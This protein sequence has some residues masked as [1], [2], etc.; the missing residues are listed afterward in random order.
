MSPALTRRAPKQDVDQL[1]K[2]KIQSSALIPLDPVIESDN[3][4]WDNADGKL[5]WMLEHEKPFTWTFEF[6]VKPDVPVGSTQEVSF[7]IEAQ[8]C[9]ESKCT[10]ENH[11][12]KVSIP[13]GPEEPLTPAADIAGRTEPVAP[14]VVPVTGSIEPSSTPGGET[15]DDT[16]GGNQPPSGLLQA[17][18][19]AVGGG[20]ISLLTP[21]V[22]PMI[23]ITVSYFLKQSEPKL[24]PVVHTPSSDQFQSFPRPP[25]LDPKPT[26]P[27]LLALV[28]SLT[29]VLVLT[30]GG[31]S[32]GSALIQIS[33]H[34][35]TNFALGAVFLF[36]G[37]SLFGWYDVTLPSWLQ[38]VT[39]SGEGRGGLLGVFFMALTFSIVSFSCVGP[40]YGIFIAG[41]AAGSSGQL[42]LV[43]SVVAFAVAFASP[44]FFLALFPQLLETMPRAGSWMNSVK[45]VMGFLEIAAVV[46]FVRAGELASTGAAEYLSY[47]LS[48]GIYVAL[49]VACGLYL[50]GVYRLPHDHD[51]PETIAVPRLL[52]GLGF[53]TLALY[54]TPGLF[55]SAGGQSM[56]PRGIVF[57]W[58]DSFRLPDP[59]EAPAGKPGAPSGETLVWNHQL[60]VALEQAKKE[61]KLV[62]IDFTGTLCTN[63]KLN[64]RYA[65]PRPEIQAAMSKYVLL[66]LYTDKTPAGVEQVPS[67]VSSLELRNKRFE[68]NA[69]PHY[70]I[71]R[72]EGDDF[73]IVRKYGGN[74]IQSP[75]ERKAFVEFLTK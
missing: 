71:L 47:D 5:D 43:I 48:L 49:C 70:A 52:F 37:L 66:K 26:S 63:C 67:E 1:A 27:L 21:C 33:T 4:T 24:L 16:T 44:F 41:N 13:I 73:R 74:L 11:T 40:I 58:I 6:F 64:E 23:P 72:P 29:I 65:F 3:A 19:I 25:V 8:V 42:R 18:L 32:L 38:D 57:G 61:N 15:G 59:E 39:A 10:I 54:M 50:L 36:F 46:K 60:A 69:L 53:L 35:V 14:V 51:A 17:I 62:F 56:Q 34:P 45:V 28:Y 2:V 55:K 30:V 68:T 9:N 75:G 20:F 12:V 7:Q 22:F 31:L